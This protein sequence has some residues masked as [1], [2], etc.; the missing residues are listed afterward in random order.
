MFR[1]AAQVHFHLNIENAPACLVIAF[2]TAPHSA[3]ALKLPE[4]LLGI[5]LYY[6]VSLILKCEKKAIAQKWRKQEAIEC[7]ES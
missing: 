2:S 3:P 5:T 1:N 4:N 6:G 7:F